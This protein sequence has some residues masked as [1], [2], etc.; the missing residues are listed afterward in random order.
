MDNLILY[1]MM[2]DDFVESYDPHCIFAHRVLSYKKIDYQNKVM[3]IPEEYKLLN[4]S[5]IQF[6]LISYNKTLYHDAEDL[7]KLFGELTP[8]NSLITG[9]V[10]DDPLMFLLFQWGAD[11]MGL[12][13]QYLAMYVEENWNRYVSDIKKSAKSTFA[14]SALKK[15]REYIVQHIKRSLLDRYDY[16]GVKDLMNKQ[17]SLIETLLSQNT[18]I[19]GSKI[20][21]AD[22]L[23]FS[24]LHSLFHPYIPE[25]NGL[26]SKYPKLI[27]WALE[28]DDLSSGSHT[29]KLNIN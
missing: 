26:K 19:S 22:L 8:G 1:S 15:E 28:I 13:V 21:I 27:N 20:N 2:G 18:Y 14:I 9:T 11:S 3:Y 29:K 25:T 17:L 24:Q 7:L 6:P 12:M 16:Q 5:I 4:E 10:E 23:V